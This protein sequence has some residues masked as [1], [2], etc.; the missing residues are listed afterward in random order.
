MNPLQD[1][2]RDNLSALKYEL[3]AEVLRS[4][5][6]LRLGVTGWSMLPTIWP[7]DTLVIEP[8]ESEE[9]FT[10]D[11]VLF[12]RD[13]RLF[14]HR[15]IAKG[16]DFSEGVVFTQGDGM[17]H[18]DAAVKKSELLGR[19]CFVLRAGRCFAPGPKLSSSERVI[20]ALVGRFY[21]AARI[22]IELH[23][24]RQQEQI[25]RCQN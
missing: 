21:W 23:V 2:V 24:M 3:A 17:S 18:P 20:A 11:I 15:V 6:R 12:E 10:G 7:G 5:G 19:V 13:E 25:A 9:V 1:A 16:D 14:V 8:A 4:S 22:L